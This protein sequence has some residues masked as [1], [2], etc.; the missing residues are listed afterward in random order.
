MSTQKRCAWCSCRMPKDA[1]GHSLCCCFGC[2]TARANK[3]KNDR[4]F[5]KRMAK[6]AAKLEILK[7]G[8]GL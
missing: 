1:H 7:R 6:Q 4:G 5:A 8:M 3:I 2:R